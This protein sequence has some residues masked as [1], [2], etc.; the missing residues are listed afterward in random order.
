MSVRIAAIASKIKMKQN[1]TKTP[2]IYD[3]IHG[4]ALHSLVM[5]QPSMFLQRGPTRPIHADIVERT[6][7]AQVF[8]HQLPRV[9]KSQLPQSRIGRDG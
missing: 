8:P 1:A 3:V 4:L 5:R 7:H 9:I 6:S 2:C